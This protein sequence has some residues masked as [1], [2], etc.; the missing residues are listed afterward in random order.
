MKERESKKGKRW[1]RKWTR[2]KRGAPAPHGA[3]SFNLG[4]KCLQK[5]LLWFF[6]I[7][8]DLSVSHVNKMAVVG[9]DRRPCTNYED[10]SVCDVMYHSPTL[11]LSAAVV[12]STVLQ[13]S[14]STLVGLLDLSQ[15]NIWACAASQ[16]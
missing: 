8:C 4:W 15:S 11:L 14:S 12:R 1:G 7:D 10:L 6:K 2:G 13:W 3:D 9:M 16:H 5:S